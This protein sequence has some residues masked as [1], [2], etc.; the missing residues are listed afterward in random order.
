MLVDSPRFL[1]MFSVMLAPSGGSFG[2]RNGRVGVMSTSYFDSAARYASL[3]FRVRF[4]TL[5]ISCA[6]SQPHDD[7]L[8]EG[9]RCSKAQSPLTSMLRPEGNILSTLS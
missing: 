2:A 9:E 8:T 4:A 3:S 7:G 5:P 1:D 6:V